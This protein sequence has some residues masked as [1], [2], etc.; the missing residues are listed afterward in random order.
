ML[1]NHFLSSVSGGKS[2]S[3]SCLKYQSSCQETITSAPGYS[4]TIVENCPHLE[5]P[6]GLIPGTIFGDSAAPRNECLLFN[7]VSSLCLPALK[8]GETD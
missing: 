6:G 5:G 1:I 4:F 2:A 3:L 7:T 8:G